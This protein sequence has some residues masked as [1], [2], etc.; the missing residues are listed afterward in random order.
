M[1]RLENLDFISV[2]CWPA[3]NGCPPCWRS[4]PQQDRSGNPSCWAWSSSTRS[5]LSGTDW[6]CKG[7]PFSCWDASLCG[8]HPCGEAHH[9]RTNETSWQV[10]A[11]IKSYSTVSV[12]VLTWV[13]QPVWAPGWDAAA[14]TAAGTGPRSDSGT[15]ATWRLLQ[16]PVHTHI[17]EQ[18]V[19]NT[20]E[21]LTRWLKC[22]F[23]SYQYL[24]GTYKTKY[25]T[26]SVCSFICKKRT[27]VEVLKTNK[28]YNHTYSK[29]TE[30]HL[31][32]L[33]WEFAWHSTDIL[34]LQR[35]R[36]SRN[37]I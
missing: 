23:I 24:F 31:G 8:N 28:K 26:N 12:C 16:S 32:L 35:F 14:H 11:S 37:H 13:W 7:S 19:S 4:H 17:Q 25:G 18:V 30:K 22:A 6:Q 5:Y 34:T 27:Q 15:G 2:K 36:V 33:S 10:A 3:W 21:M 20:G 29:R 9:T 1:P